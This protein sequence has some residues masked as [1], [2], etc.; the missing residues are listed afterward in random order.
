M[1]NRTPP[2]PISRSQLCALLDAPLPTYRRA[3]VGATTGA[4]MLVYRNAAAERLYGW[5]AEVAVGEN[6]VEMNTP[7]GSRDQAQ[8]SMGLLRAGQPWSGE[9]WVRAQGRRPPLAVFVM[10]FP[11]GDLV[12][13]RGFIVGVSVPLAQARLIAGDQARIAAE[14]DRRLHGSHLARL[15]FGGLT[16]KAVLAASRNRVGRPGGRYAPIGS[17]RTV[18]SLHERVPPPDSPWERMQRIETYR[19]WAEG[20]GGDG[21]ILLSGQARLAQMWRGLAERLAVEAGLQDDYEDHKRSAAH[22]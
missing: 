4:G 11:V 1:L 19:L 21:T 15:P 5:K 20:L 13:G 18:Y 17:L 22:G 16:A 14:L 7:R 3:A 8:E 12:H 10:G 6:A 2:A 9:V